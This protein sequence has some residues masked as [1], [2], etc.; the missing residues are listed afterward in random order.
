VNLDSLGVLAA[1]AA[2]AAY[3]GGAF[4][5]VCAVAAAGGGRLSPAP[6]RWPVSSVAAAAC[7]LV[8]CAL[9]PLPGSPAASLPDH[10]GAAP[11]LVAVLVL[12]AAAITLSG[13]PRWDRSRV[14]AAVAVTAALLTLGTAAAT[15][16]FPVLVGLPGDDLT[17]ARLAAAAAVLLA[18]PHL[19][20]PADL[21]APRGARG[22]MLAT[23]V[24]LAASL[25]LP[26]A[27]ASLPALLTAGLVVV[28]AA[29]YAAVVAVLGRRS[30]GAVAATLA[31]TAAA[32][33][34]AFSV[35]AGR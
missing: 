8:A 30:V 16:A 4:A 15:Y 28:A 27:L 26:R 10:G 17:H 31:A 23:C 29:A 34:I 7:A 24:V 22:L 20:A 19:A 32:A 1:I 9:L 5:G 3:P 25:V 18:G 33:S 11:N 35:L 14:I 21:S 12:L 6:S 13:A 2:V